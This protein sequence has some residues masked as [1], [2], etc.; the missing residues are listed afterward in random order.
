MY[1][2]DQAAVRV[3]DFTTAPGRVLATVARTAATEDGPVL[4]G[5]AAEVGGEQGEDT[6]FGNKDITELRTGSPDALL[7]RI[8]W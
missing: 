6:A 7:V 4:T 3:E 1:G 2:A 8:P 5:E